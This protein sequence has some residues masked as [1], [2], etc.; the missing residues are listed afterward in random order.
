MRGKAQATLVIEQATAGDIAD[1]LIG[2][3]GDGRA[4]KIASAVRRKRDKKR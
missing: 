2:S 1:L 4:E 3:L